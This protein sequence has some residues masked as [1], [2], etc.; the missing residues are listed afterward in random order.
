VTSPNASENRLTVHTGLL[1][2][3]VAALW[4]ASFLFM[5]VAVPVLGPVVLIEARVLL[6]GLALFVV[7]ALLRQPPAWR[8]D[9]KGYLVLGALAAG[10][11]TLIATAELRIT[12]S[13]AAILNATVPLFTLLIGAARGQETLTARRLAGV[14]L[15]MLGVAVLVGLGPLHPDATLLAATGASLLAALLLAAGGVYAK[16]RF[17]TTPPITLATG[18]QLAAAALLLPP[19]LALPRTRSLTSVPEPPSWPSP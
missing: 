12:A 2:L 17:P 10:P 13:L 4:G 18:Q 5:R 19:S 11:F 9:W 14:L 16:T 3:T 1:L 8:K 6:A 7:V 15:G